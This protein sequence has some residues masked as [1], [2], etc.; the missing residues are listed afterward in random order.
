MAQLVAYIKEVNGRHIGD[1]VFY[2]EIEAGNLIAQG[3]VMDAKA[4]QQML[5]DRKER[6]KEMRAIREDKK[7]EKPKAK[8]VKVAKAPEAPKKNKMVE[9]PKKKKAVGKSK[10]EPAEP[11]MRWRK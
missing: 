5:E 7:E 10:S 11:V 1:G 4:Y 6:A 2:D 3:I 8:V 9:A